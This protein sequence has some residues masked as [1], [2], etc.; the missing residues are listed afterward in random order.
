MRFLPI[1]LT[2][3]ASASALAQTDTPPIPSGTVV[4]D[5]I[6]TEP[7]LR[8]RYVL[9]TVAHPSGEGIVVLLGDGNRARGPIAARVLTDAGWSERETAL[10]IDFW[11]GIA[12]GESADG[13]PILA[14]AVGTQDAPE[15]L[16]TE[17]VQLVEQ[18][19]SLGVELVFT[20][21]GLGN[22][23][24]VPFVL[25]PRTVDHLGEDQ[26]AFSGIARGS[27]TALH[28][29]AA[30]NTAGLLRNSGL[31][32]NA[33]WFQDV[34]AIGGA[35]YVVGRW[36]YIDIGVPR[37]VLLGRVDPQGIVPIV[38]MEGGTAQSAQHKPAALLAWGDDVLMLG[39]YAVATGDRLGAVLLSAAGETKGEVYTGLDGINTYERV[40]GSPGNLFLIGTARLTDYTTEPYVHTECLYVAAVSDNVTWDA[41]APEREG[42]MQGS[43][44]EVLHA[45]ATESSVTVLTLDGRSRRVV[46]HVFTA[47]E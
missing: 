46:R 45:E 20:M 39:E 2:L 6:T 26:Y 25:Q 13:Q 11:T 21:P 27:E 44:T 29:V 7:L 9:G 34:V 41:C 18:G 4:V 12:T 8:S 42:K 17:V 15:S 5:T 33:G 30:A 43:G 10:G 19:D 37:T 28:W 1:W 24:G 36:G 16:K 38:K 35:L 3:L 23:N 14:T 47:P 22:L 31:A 32:E 40:V